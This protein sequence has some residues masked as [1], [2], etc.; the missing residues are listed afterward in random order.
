[1]TDKIIIIKVILGAIAALGAI[2]TITLLVLSSLT[3][4]IINKWHID[5]MYVQL[6]LQNIT[7]WIKKSGRIT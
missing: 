6:I 1:M 5:A 4:I 7:R 2:A 3:G